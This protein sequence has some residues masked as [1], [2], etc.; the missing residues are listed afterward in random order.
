[1]NKITEKKLLELGFTKEFVS[2]EE[3]GAKEFHYFVFEV[4]DDCLLISCAN[5]ETNKGG[6]TVEFF[7]F[8]GLKY[9]DYKI[10]KNLVKFIKL[11]MS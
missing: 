3:S 8:N 4:N 2:A 10:L 11:G 6:Y 9:S 7:N 1:M 5:D